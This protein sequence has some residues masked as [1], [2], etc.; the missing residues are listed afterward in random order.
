M[1]FGFRPEYAFSFAG[2]PNEVLAGGPYALPYR[3]WN[4]YVEELVRV[5]ATKAITNRLNEI[6]DT[7]RNAY[8]HPD[9]NVTLE[10]APIQFELCTGVMYLMAD[11]IEKKT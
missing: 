8:T 4:R 6:R 7:D 10:E 3:N 11:E 5:G 2:I 1:P 9:R